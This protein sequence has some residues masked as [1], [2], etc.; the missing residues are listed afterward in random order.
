M[1]KDPLLDGLELLLAGLACTSSKDELGTELPLLGDLPLLL[2][3]LVDN[4]VVVLE[5]GA[6][7]L[8]L[9]RNP[10]GV[11][12]HGRCVLGPVAEVVCVEREG[13]AEVLDGLGVLEE[14]NLFTVLDTNG[15][16]YSYEAAG[17][18]RCGHGGACMS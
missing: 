13:L 8:S 11:L 1:D 2:S 3:T 17:A 18:R 7:A 12:V 4:G 16:S 14:E 5:V 15:Q 10:G 9:K 6:E